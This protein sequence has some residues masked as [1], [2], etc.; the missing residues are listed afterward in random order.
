[1]D[2]P[3]T[4]TGGRAPAPC[5]PAGGPTRDRRSPG[6]DLPDHVVRLRGRPGR[7]RPLR[8]AEVRQHLQPPRQP[9]RGG[10]RGARREPRGRDRRGGDGQRPGGLDDGGDGARGRRR[11]RRVPARRSTAGPTYCSTSRCAGWGS[12]RPSSRPTTRTPSRR[13]SSPGRTKL[14]F[15]ETVANPAGTVA[16]LEALSG[17]SPATPACRSSSTRRSPPR[18][19]AGRS[20]TAPTSWCTP[21]RSSSAATARRW[22]ASWS[23]RG[24]SRGTT[25]TSR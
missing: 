1:M 2:V 5:T 24:R 21:R 14:L 4:A 16:D 9:D 8:P 20:I 25:A 10:L 7:R 17:R 11:P 15:T 13:R 22:A 6:A 18:T 12:R 3:R 23:T 19:C